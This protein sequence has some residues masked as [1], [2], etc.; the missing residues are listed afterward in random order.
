MPDISLKT[1]QAYF[2]KV[3]RANYQASM[4]LEGF[5]PSTARAKLT[6]EAILAKYSRSR[7]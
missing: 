6:K 3:K 7:S 1:K 2:A 5:T 4:H